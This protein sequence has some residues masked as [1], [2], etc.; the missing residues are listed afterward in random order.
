MTDYNMLPNDAIILA[1]CKSAG[2]SY[3]ASY[4]SDFILP[5]QQEGITLI[6]SI[7]TFQRIFS[8]E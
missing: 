4:D 2:I 5:C 8:V 3:L 1:H 6:D 7:E